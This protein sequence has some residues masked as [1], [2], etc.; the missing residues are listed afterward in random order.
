MPNVTL[1]AINVF[2]LIILLATVGA[3]LP[4]VTQ[5]K[6]DSKLMAESTCVDPLTAG[7]C[8][9]SIRMGQQLG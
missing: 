6:S 2:Y 4:F 9:V 5:T 8:V 7:N 3:P 1:M